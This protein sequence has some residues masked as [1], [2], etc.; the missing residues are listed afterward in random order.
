M[1]DTCGCVRECRGR[2]LPATHTVCPLCQ[3]SIPSSS[4]FSVP[5]LISSACHH[6]PQG[7][8]PLPAPARTPPSRSGLS[9]GL[10]GAG[11]LRAGQGGAGWRPATHTPNLR[12]AREGRG[13]PPGYL[14][15]P[16]C[17]PPERPKLLS[18]R[19]VS[20][21]SACPLGR[22]STQVPKTRCSSGWWASTG[23]RR[24]DGACGRRGAR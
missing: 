4:T 14:G 7:L 3:V 20:T 5:L 19:W 21:A 8:R 15:R 10:R 12:K 23:R 9:S 17:F 1:C 22:R 18:A 6:L 2:G 16:L 24:S 13:L 11:D